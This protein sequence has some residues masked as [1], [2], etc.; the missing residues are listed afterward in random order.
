MKKGST[1]LVSFSALTTGSGSGDFIYGV[2]DG[3]QKMKFK[4]PQTWQRHDVKISADSDGDLMLRWQ[5]TAMGEGN[6]V[7]I[8][9]FSLFE[10]GQ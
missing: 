1:Y 7:Y 3:E 5:N 10:T 2:G 9:E 8:R 4:S 6:A